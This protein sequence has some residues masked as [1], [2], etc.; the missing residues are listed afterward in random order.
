MKTPATMTK[1]VKIEVFQ[2]FH[3]PNHF[4]IKLVKESFIPEF[5]ASSLDSIVNPVGP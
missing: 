3:F 2:P 5:S 1:E 4:Y